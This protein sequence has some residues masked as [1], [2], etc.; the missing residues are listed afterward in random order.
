MSLCFNTNTSRVCL[1]VSPL[2]QNSNILQ[3]QVGPSSNIGMDVIPQIA[4]PSV[5]G[6]QSS[7]ESV[8]IRCNTMISLI[9]ET[10]E[11]FGTRAQNHADQLYNEVLNTPPTS[12][13]YARNFLG[14]VQFCRDIIR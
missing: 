12:S 13:E 2:N 4:G 6:V 1:S 14:Y 3:T 10:D 7:L 8:R 5:G 11:D 9:K